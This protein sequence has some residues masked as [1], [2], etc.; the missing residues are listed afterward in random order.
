MLKKSKTDFIISL[1]YLYFR[2]EFGVAVAEITAA[3]N[4]LIDCKEAENANLLASS[5][6]LIAETEILHTS[7]TRMNVRMNFVSV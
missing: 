7:Y 5:R 2:S 6:E 4:M 3:H 1:I